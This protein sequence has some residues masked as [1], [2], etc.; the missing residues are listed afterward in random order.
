MNLEQQMREALDGHFWTIDHSQGRTIDLNSPPPPVLAT[1]PARPRHPRHPPQGDET[2]THKD[3]LG[4]I[5]K[6]IAKVTA[7]TTSQI[8]GPRCDPDTVKVRRLYCW[9]ADEFTDLSTREIGRAVNRDA[10]TIQNG[11]DTVWNNKSD[12][13]PWLCQAWAALSKAFPY[14]SKESQC[15]SPALHIAPGMEGGPPSVLSIPNHSGARR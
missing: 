15:A 11:I 4:E 9:A 2:S 6:I 13:E 7:V 1:K 5:L 10:S 3:R 14:K 12:F 8:S